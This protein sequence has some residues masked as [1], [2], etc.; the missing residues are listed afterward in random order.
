MSQNYYK[1]G[2]WSAICD[3]CGFKFKS[4]QL[5]K[6]W[7]GMMVCHIDFETR[8]P[9]DFLPPQQ[10]PKVLPWTRPEPED[11]YISVTYGNEGTQVTSVPDGTY[12][13]EEPSL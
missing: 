3:V 6:R 13:P 11:T 9:A 4:D 12:T 2:T 7:D 1:P 8:H 5:V 10:V